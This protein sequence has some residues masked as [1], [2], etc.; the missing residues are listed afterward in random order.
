M[1]TN[2]PIEGKHSVMQHHTLSYLK[3]FIEDVNAFCDVVHSLGYLLDKGKHDPSI[4][5]DFLRSPERIIA[6]AWSAVMV[7]LSRFIPNHHSYK[8][9][10]GP[11]RNMD[12]QVIILNNATRLGKEGCSQIWKKSG[13]IEKLGRTDNLGKVA[14][15]SP[16]C[17]VFPQGGRMSINLYKTRQSLHTHHLQFIERCKIVQRH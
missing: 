3:L 10:Q 13:E 6:H 16:I 12:S 8:A 9:T 1:D 2:R 14:R 15:S 7:S 4:L 5:P 11:N 17:M